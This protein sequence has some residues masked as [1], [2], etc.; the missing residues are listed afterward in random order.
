MSCNGWNHSASCDCGWGGMWHGNVPPG[1]EAFYCSDDDP[2]AVAAVSIHKSLKAG[3]PRSLTIPN[4]KCPAGC[5]ASVFYYQNEYGSRVFFDQLGPPWPK[6]SCTDNSRYDSPSSGRVLAPSS[7]P[8]ERHLRWQREGWRPW[9][10]ARKHEW[11]VILQEFDGAEFI[12]LEL[13]SDVLSSALPIVFTKIRSKGTVV[14]SFFHSG[15]RDGSTR[16]VPFRN[17]SRQQFDTDA[18][19][20]DKK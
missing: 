15:I 3:Q 5:G 16:I 8:P 17:M 18:A 14:L 11:R 7:P 10:I 20:A 6:H 13:P 19:V 2:S 9:Q 1:G 4:A 12:C